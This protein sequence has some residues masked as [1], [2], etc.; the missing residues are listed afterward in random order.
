MA[1]C[2][3]CV[4]LKHFRRP[5]KSPP[6]GAP[7]LPSLFDRRDRRSHLPEV[8][9]LGAGGAGPGLRSL[10]SEA[11]GTHPRQGGEDPTPRAGSAGFEVSSRSRPLALGRWTPMFWRPRARHPSCP[12]LG[13]AE[14]AWAEADRP[15][16]ATRRP[17][18]LQGLRTCFLFQPFLAFGRPRGTGI[19]V[20]VCVCLFGRPQR[21]GPGTPRLL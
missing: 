20:S 11:S 7:L 4:V 8:T 5:R 9:L 19:A 17:H 12:G 15:T 16:Q 2:Q 21:G 10:R 6:W 13:G 18:P 1:L 14:A 3:A